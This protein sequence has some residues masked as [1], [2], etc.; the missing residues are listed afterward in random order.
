[1]VAM[2]LIFPVAVYVVVSVV[3]FILYAID[4]RRAIESRRRIRESTLHLAELLGGFP[5][6]FAAQRTL[7]HKNRKLTY[8]VTFWLIVVLHLAGWAAYLRPFGF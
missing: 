5:G 1:M 6:A 4:K 7:R 2:Q 3:T 8:Q